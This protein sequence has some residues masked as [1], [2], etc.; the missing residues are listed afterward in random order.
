MWSPWRNCGGGKLARSRPTSEWVAQDRYV[1]QTGMRESGLKFPS[2]APRPGIVSRS[3]HS[4]KLPARRKQQTCGFRKSRRKINTCS[5]DRQ[6]VLVIKADTLFSP[7]L[8]RI[9]GVHCIK[10]CIYMYC[11]GLY[12][13]RLTQKFPEKVTITRQAK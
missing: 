3:L 11:T 5:T 12:G 7:R 4:V 2:K 10:F 9:R 8:L 6:I 13:Q 1:A